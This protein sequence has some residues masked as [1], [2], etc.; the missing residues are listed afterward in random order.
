[1]SCSAESMGLRPEFDR[2]GPAELWLSTPHPGSASIC[3][4]CT[5]PG[6]GPPI[7]SLTGRQG[8]GKKL[9]LSL[10][11]PDC[12]QLEIIHR[13]KRHSLGRL[14]LK[15]VSMAQLIL[16]TPPCSQSQPS[17]QSPLVSLPGPN[18]TSPR[19]SPDLTPQMR[20]DCSVLDVNSIL[21][22]VTLIF[23]EPVPSPCLSSTFLNLR[24]TQSV[25]RASR[26]Q[27][28]SLIFLS[29]LT[30]FKWT[31]KAGVQDCW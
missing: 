17:P 19:A 31:E 2:T 20:A 8:E 15:S 13:P 7:D 21:H 23:K 11:G 6:P 28:Q 16:R 9:F 26:R 10:L 5:L 25:P 12:L 29:T 3:G 22:Y 30:G 24:L 1:M 4:G 18:S 27:K 14:V